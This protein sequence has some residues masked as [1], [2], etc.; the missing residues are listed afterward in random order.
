MNSS[1]T[2]RIGVGL[3]SMSVALQM[4]FSLLIYLLVMPLAFLIVLLGLDE[5]GQAKRRAATGG[6]GE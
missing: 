3:V 4:W 5:H 2:S 6:E 1:W